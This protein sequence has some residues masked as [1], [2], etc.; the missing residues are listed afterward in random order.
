MTL[1]ASEESPDCDLCLNSWISIRQAKLTSQIVESMYIGAPKI[2]VWI[3][4][5]E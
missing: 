2:R 4:E 5:I 3:S 1:D